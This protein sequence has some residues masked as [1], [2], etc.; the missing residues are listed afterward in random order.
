[1]DFRRDALTSGNKF[2]TL[3]VLDD[4]NRE[5]LAMEIAIFLAATRVIRTLEQLIDWRGKPAAIR[6]DNGPEFTSADFTSWCKEKGIKSIIFSRV[7]PCKMAIWSVSTAVTDG[8]SCMLI[9]SLNWK[10][11]EIYPASE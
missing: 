4:C 5:A 11:S 9:C 3:N 10:R 7:N 2:R 6:V 8:K 1:M